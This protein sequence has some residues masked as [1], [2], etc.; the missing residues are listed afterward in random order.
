MFIALTNHQHICMRY[1]YSLFIRIYTHDAIKHVYILLWSS[2]S[3]IAETKCY[4]FLIAEKIR[5]VAIY[6]LFN[7]KHD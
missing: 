4:I 1:L 6:Y 2:F 3:I 7:D 5:N